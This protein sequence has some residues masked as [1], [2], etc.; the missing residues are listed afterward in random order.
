MKLGIVG[1]VTVETVM[2]PVLPVL[3]ADAVVVTLVV[4]YIQV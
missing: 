3:T 4:L 2:V 1:G